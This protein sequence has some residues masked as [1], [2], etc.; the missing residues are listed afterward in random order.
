MG[1][2]INLKRLNEWVEPQHLGLGTL[3]E[4][5]V[6]NDWMVKVDLKDAYFTVPTHVIHQ[7]MLCFQVEPEHYQ[8]TCQPFSLS[9]A[10]WVFTK[11]MK[12]VA[13]FLLS[14]G[15]QM[16]IYTDDK[17][18]MVESAAS[19]GSPTVTVD[20]PRTNVP[21]SVT[22]LLSKIEYLGL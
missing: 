14:M 2:A 15:V 10:P 9:C 1:P 4:L 5:L 20:R 13:I 22:S 12:P 7:P 11:V 16:I 3:R 18:L 19:S 17:L 6:L 21:K 8:F